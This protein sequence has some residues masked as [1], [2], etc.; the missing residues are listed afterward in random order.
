V[1]RSFTSSM[2]SMMPRPRTSPMRDIFPS[3]LP[4]VSE[5]GAQLRG[6]AGIVVTLHDLNH[7]Q[8]GGGGYGVAAVGAADPAHMGGVHDLC[9]AGDGGD[10]Q[11]AGNG[12]G[13]CPHV[14]SGGPVFGGEEFAGAA[15][16]GL[17]FVGDQQDA[18]FVTDLAQ[19]ADVFV[20]R[21]HKPAFPLEGFEDD[22][23][24]VGGGHFFQEEGFKLFG[25]EQ[26]TGLALLAVG[27][28]VAVGEQH[29]VDAG[30]K[31]AELEFVGLDFAG[32][33]HG[34]VGP[35]VE[36][37]GEDDDFASLVYL[38]AILTAFSMASAPLLTSM[39]FLGK[40]P[41]RRLFMCS[42]TRMYCS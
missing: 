11:A 30:C 7:F 31:G 29:P 2:A 6:F 18:V 38:R 13:C 4:A 15:E 10:G 21:Q 23:G 32:H 1:V 41:G 24:H 39:V 40:S 17:D 33:A 35:A 42:A 16:G 25:T 22:G 27:T 12:F 19:H 34:Q 3:G 28:A 36:G 9:A 5:K 20:G 14:G 37:A 8:G 26:V